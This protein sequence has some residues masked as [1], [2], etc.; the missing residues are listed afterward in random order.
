MN[1]SLVNIELQ[2]YPHRAIEPLQ[3]I[4]RIK[5][6]IQLGSKETLIFSSCIVSFASNDTSLSTLTRAVVQHSLT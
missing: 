5:G 6:N 1:I 3:I 4:H 2:M